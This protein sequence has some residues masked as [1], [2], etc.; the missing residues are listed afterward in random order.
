MTTKRIFVRG[1]F[2]A[3]LNYGLVPIDGQRNYVFQQ[4]DDDSDHYNDEADKDDDDQMHIT[5]G[6]NISKSSVMVI[7]MFLSCTTFGGGHNPKIITVL[8][9][10]SIRYTLQSMPSYHIP[11]QYM[12]FLSILHI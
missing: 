12:P 6:G 8:V 2:E 1:P 5:K 9:Q 7:C 4:L 11:N 10:Q 3:P